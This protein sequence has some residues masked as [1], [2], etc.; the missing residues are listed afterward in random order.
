M[1]KEME[2]FKK[3]IDSIH[4]SMVSVKNHHFKTYQQTNE[5]I[6]ENL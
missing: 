5:L 1:G 4:Q 2:N 3:E 6:L